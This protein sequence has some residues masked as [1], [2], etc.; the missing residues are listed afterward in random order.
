MFIIDLILWLKGLFINW[1]LI[2]LNEE[3]YKLALPLGN[4]NHLPLLQDNPRPE[5][6]WL[7]C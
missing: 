1:I 3:L 4:S 2:K 5:S 6:I 7:V